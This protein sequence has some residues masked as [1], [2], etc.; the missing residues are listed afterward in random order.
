[1]YADNNP[2]F[3]WSREWLDELAM[4]N[5]GSQEDTQRVASSGEVDGQ[6]RIQRLFAKGRNRR[7]RDDWRHNLSE[8]THDD[9]DEEGEAADLGLGER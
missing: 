3:L 5:E 8:F 1:M 6:V 4:I 2:D 9:E 7:F